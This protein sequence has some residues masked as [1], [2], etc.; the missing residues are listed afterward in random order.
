MPQERMLPLTAGAMLVGQ[1]LHTHTSVRG[2]VAPNLHPILR[3]LIHE[4]P[5]EQLERFAGWCAETVLISDRLY[6]AEELA[7][8]LTAMQARSALWGSQLNVVHILQDDD[9][10]HGENVSPCR[11]CQ[12]LLDH[13]GMEVIS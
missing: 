4:L 3:R 6:A 5:V 2:D 1:T 10:R 13:F 9:P 12:A 11:T 7:G 8:T